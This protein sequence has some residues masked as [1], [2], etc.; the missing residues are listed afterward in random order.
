MLF[1]KGGYPMNLAKLSLSQ[2]EILKTSGEFETSTY[3]FNL[4]GIT[5]LI[6]PG[7]G[8]GGKVKKDRQVDVIITHGHYD[9]ISGLPEIDFDRIYISPED[10]IALTDPISNLS[11][12]FT[13]PFAFEVEWYNIDEYFQTIVAPGHTPGSRIIIFE[14]VIFTGDVVFSNSIGRVDLYVDKLEQAEMRKQMTATIKRLRG[15][16]KTLPEDWYICPGHGDIV[17]IKR[18]FE[19]N[20][21]FK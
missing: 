3:K 17:T 9:H 12:F 5:Y 19:I 15:L 18:L 21:F 13:E 16:F 1:P 10:S 4:D 14:G 2:I 7:F 8:I 6:D 20:P 11:A